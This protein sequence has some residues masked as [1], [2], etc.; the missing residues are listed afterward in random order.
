MTKSGFVSV[1][2]RPN[3]GKSTLLNRILGEKISIISDKPQTTRDKIQLIYTDENTQ[4]IFLD[5]PGM[6]NPRNKLGEHMLSTS[7]GSVGEADVILYLVDTSE[8]IG[9]REK[10]II[11]FL[12]GI[13]VPIILVINKIDTIERGKILALMDMYK[14]VENISEIVPISATGGE[15][16]DELIGVIKKHLPEGPFFYPDDYITDK[17]ERFIVGEIIREKA[18]INLKEEVPHGISV[19]VDS[20]KEKED[21]TFDI[22]ATIYSEK[23]SHKGII[24]GK[25]G[26]MIKKIRQEATRD[27]ERFL[28]SKI[29]L[30]LWVKIEKNWRER[31]SKVKY[32]GY[33]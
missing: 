30:E 27:I 29:T 15:G 22:T 11:E 8:F 32:F 13:D 26:T 33:Q 10:D 25:Q 24:I 21:G 7:R 5:T 14:D 28:D 31:E 6:Q 19:L 9:S 18:L 16:V 20:M 17:S 23:D 12:Q 3:V 4:M 2:G 1:I